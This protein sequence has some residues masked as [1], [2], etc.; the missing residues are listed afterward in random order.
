MV[1]SI[2]CASRICSKVHEAIYC[3]NLFSVD[4]C[5]SWMRKCNYKAFHFS[6]NVHVL[7]LTTGITASISSWLE[8]GKISVLV[9]CVPV[10][11]GTNGIQCW[12]YYLSYRVWDSRAG[13]WF[14]FTNPLRQNS[15][16]NKIQ[17]AFF[18]YN[19]LF[20]W[21]SGYYGK[22]RQKVNLY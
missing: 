12:S 21:W 22:G 5:L 4:F 10:T 17:S 11:K 18:L 1:P 16:W 6:F 19:Q 13:S 9:L 3:F 20:L 2:S 8:I 14:H 15:T 7:Q